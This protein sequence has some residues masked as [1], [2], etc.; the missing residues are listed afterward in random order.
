MAT[1]DKRLKATLID[2]DQ[3]LATAPVAFTKT[4]I[5]FPFLRIALLVARRFFYGT[6]SSVEAHAR[7]ND[8]T[9]QS[10]GR[11]PFGCDPGTARPAGAGLPSPA[12]L[13]LG[14]QA[15]YKTSR[16]RT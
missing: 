13:A 6:A 9:H 1:G 15:A 14:G 2:I 12:A 7:Y 10:D 5:S 8:G 4:K 11:V 3:L 16:Q